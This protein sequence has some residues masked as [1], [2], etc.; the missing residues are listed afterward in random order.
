MSIKEDFTL[1]EKRKI[2][3][4]LLDFN[5]S[6][7]QINYILEKNIK[8]DNFYSIF[9]CFYIFFFSILVNFF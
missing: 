1:E 9:L 3:K 8:D 7:K 4:V 6:K 2:K 5:F